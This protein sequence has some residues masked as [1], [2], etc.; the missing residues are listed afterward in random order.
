ME[1]IKSKFWFSNPYTDKKGIEQQAIVILEID[2]RTK[3]YSIKPYCGTINEGFRFEQ[4]SHKWQLW[5]AILKSI[6]EAID[7]ANEELRMQ[8]IDKE[9]EKEKG[10]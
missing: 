8:E 2:Y 3:Q 4:C 9:L 5:K 7:F 1:K 6:N 10:L